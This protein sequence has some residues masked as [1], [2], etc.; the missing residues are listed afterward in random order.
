MSESLEAELEKFR[1][2]FSIPRETALN[3]LQTA[4]LLINEDSPQRLC[5]SLVTLWDDWDVLYVEVPRRRW[6]AK[7]QNNCA[8]I[9]AATTELLRLVPGDRRSLL[10]YEL[11]SY[12][13][14]PGET[15]AILRRL[16]DAAGQAATVYPLYE[17][18]RRRGEGRET[19]LFISLR[20]LYKELGG[21]NRI[22]SN[23]PLYRFVSACVDAMGTGISVPEPESFRILMMKAQRRRQRG[24][25]K[26]PS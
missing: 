7:W 6:L 2:S 13:V 18:R 23:G 21:S 14:D 22:G 4:K 10:L 25:V 15:A 3:I 19:G 5:D 16:R 12:G 24:A 20:E 17:T 8:R 11:S 9:R 1:R 26:T